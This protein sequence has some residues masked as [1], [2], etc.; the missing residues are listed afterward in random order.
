MLSP[1]KDWRQCPVPVVWQVFN[2]NCRLQFYILHLA[3]FGWETQTSLAKNKKTKKTPCNYLISIAVLKTFWRQQK[4]TGN[5]MWG[6]V[7]KAIAL[8]WLQT[9]EEG[10]Q[11]KDVRGIFSSATLPVVCCVF[12]W[13][14]T[15][16]WM[17]FPVWSLGDA[18]SNFSKASCILFTTSRCVKQ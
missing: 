11:Q 8:I 3:L 14:L 12:V 1:R 4:V 7:P 2:V 6:V 9:E 18:Q 16:V 5:L 10:G 17:R 15:V 13:A